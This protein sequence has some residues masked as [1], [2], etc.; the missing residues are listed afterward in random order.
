MLLVGT[1]P[2]VD[3]TYAIAARLSRVALT[4]PAGAQLGRY[5]IVKQLASGLMAELLLARA[6]GLGG[7]ERHFVIKRIRAEQGRFEMS[8]SLVLDAPPKV[9]LPQLAP[10]APAAPASPPMWR[11]RLCPSSSPNS[12]AWNHSTM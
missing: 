9:Q 2:N 12:T 5:E 10:V 4:V 1:P 6:R 3:G 7:F 11:P 8:K